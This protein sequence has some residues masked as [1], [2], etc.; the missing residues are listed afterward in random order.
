LSI[1]IA[2]ATRDARPVAARCRSSADDTIAVTFSVSA[3]VPAPQQ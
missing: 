1:V 2:V 3:A